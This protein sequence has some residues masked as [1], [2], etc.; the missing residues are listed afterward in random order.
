VI[1]TPNCGRVVE[2]GKT[3]FIVPARNAEALADAIGKFALDRDLAPGMGASCRAAA[4]A[5]SIDAYGKALAKVIQE[6]LSA[7]GREA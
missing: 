3:G 2:E 6:R 7:A 5:F 1:T 4:E